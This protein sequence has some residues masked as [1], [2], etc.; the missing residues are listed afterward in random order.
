L[1]LVDQLVPHSLS[2]RVSLETRSLHRQIKSLSHTAFI[3]EK[4]PKTAAKVWPPENKFIT[5]HGNAKN[6]NKYKTIL[7]HRI[8]TL[9]HI[10]APFILQIR[11]LDGWFAFS[12]G[13]LVTLR[14]HRDPRARIPFF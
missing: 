3:R 7:L 6:Y 2:L 1:A 13:F 8:Q 4:R 11:N 12:G 9:T 10:A 14:A 5:T